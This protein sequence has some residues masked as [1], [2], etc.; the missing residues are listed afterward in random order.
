MFVAYD[1]AK[2]HPEDILLGAPEESADQTRSEHGT[3]QME[4]PQAAVNGSTSGVLTYQ[5]KQKN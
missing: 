2:K 3:A 4:R 1:L 5:P